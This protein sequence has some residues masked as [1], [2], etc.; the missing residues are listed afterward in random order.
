[1]FLHIIQ[2]NNQDIVTNKHAQDYNAHNLTYFLQRFQGK[3]N[4]I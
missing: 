1:M 2:A 3:C 4:S